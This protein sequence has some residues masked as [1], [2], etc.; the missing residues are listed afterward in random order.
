MAIQ[1]NP[2]WHVWLGD[3]WFWVSKSPGVFV[4]VIIALAA[5]IIYSNSPKITQTFIPPQQVVYRTPPITVQPQV[6]PAPHQLAVPQLRA[7]QQTNVQTVPSL[8]QANF[9]TSQ[10][11]AL[12]PPD[13]ID[14]EGFGHCGANRGWVPAYHSCI[15]TLPPSQSVSQLSRQ[16]CSNGAVWS[17][18][19]QTCVTLNP[20]QPAIQGPPIAGI[21]RTIEHPPGTPGQFR[22]DA[23]TGQPTGGPGTGNA[24]CD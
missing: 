22:C 23:A 21:R 20:S 19:Y 7:L 14:S 8:Q 4:A 6:N 24:W 2:D 17:Q 16:P 11:N 3:V 5:Y 1:K 13:Y 10:S 18:E 15:S 9:P 12:S